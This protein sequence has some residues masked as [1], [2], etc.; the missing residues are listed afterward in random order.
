MY[1]LLIIAGHLSNFHLTV[2]KR[3]FLQTL[4]FFESN[5]LSYSNK[6]KW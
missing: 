1:A 2:N 6:M 5:L 4:S 3:L